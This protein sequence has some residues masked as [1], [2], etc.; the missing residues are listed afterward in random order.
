MAIIEN[1]QQI[2]ITNAVTLVS[3][4]RAFRD[5]VKERTNL[6][7]AACQN[8]AR[9]QTLV[10]PDGNPLA[11]QVFGWRE[12]DENWWDIEGLA[13]SS[14]ITMA[15]RYESEPFWINEEGIRTRHPNR[16]LDALDLTK[17]E[18][19]AKTHAAIVA[20]VHLPFGEVGAVSFNPDDPS[21]TDLAEE[22]ERFGDELGIYADVFI[23]SYVHTMARYQQLPV[24]SKLSKREVECLH[25]SAVGKT[26]AEI[27]IIIG[28][29]RATVRFHL[30]NA[31]TKLNAVNKSQAVFKATQLGYISICQ[32]VRRPA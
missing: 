4:A 20:P 27:S 1:L 14:P 17:F 18:Q 21:K 29:S 12:R 13:L 6:R 9:N 25:W 22:Y 16:F 32:P 24:G 7:V 2:R 5:I 31:A 30:R 10:D 26:D 8:I 15:C 11:T 23:R 19:R 28:R 3:R